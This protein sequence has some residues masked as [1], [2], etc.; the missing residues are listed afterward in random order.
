MIH[1]LNTR[2]LA[3]FTFIIIVIMGTVFFFTY[4]TTRQEIGRF[5]ERFE[6][7]QDARVEMELSRYFLFSRSWDGVQPLVVQWGNLY[8]HR[9]IL[10]DNQGI[11]VAD[12]DTTL[13][14]TTYESDTPGYRMRPMAGMGQPTGVLYVIHGELPDINRAALQIANATIG[15][16]FLWGGLLAIIIAILLTFLLSRRILAPVK[17]LSQ[18]ARQ[19]GKG[20]FSQRVESADKGELGELATSFNSM[21]E[22]LERTERLRRNM[23]ADIA[24]EL[25]TPLSNLNGYLEAIRDGV[26]QP[27]E[28]TIASLN[29]EAA[30]LARLVEDLQEISISDAGE[31]NLIFQ[32]DDVG[33]LVRETTNGLQA[34]ATAKGLTINVDISEDLPQANI[35]SHRIRQVLNNLLENAI[36]HTASGGRITV[37]ARQREGRIYVSVADNGEGIPAEDLPNIF[38][39]FYRVDK[40]RSRATGGSGLGLTIARR[41]VEAHGGRIEVESQMGYGSIFTFDIP[42][43]NRIQKTS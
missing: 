27:E 38:E 41:I 8:G 31:L 33:R 1:S 36:A 25:R 13:L 37:T 12:S 24:H 42:M 29:E 19:F 9:I 3:A 16:F 11:V 18:A 6:A 28:A 2:L 23:V 10:T 5:G 20:D 32:P 39:R 14:G 35:D 15:R 40:S 22:D 30:T 17:A 26:I 43:L 7:L 34:K 4:L 21:A